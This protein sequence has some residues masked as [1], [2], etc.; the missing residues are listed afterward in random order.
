M[1]VHVF[2]LF[3]RHITSLHFVKMHFCFLMGFCLFYSFRKFLSFL[4]SLV[5]LCLFGLPLTLE[6]SGF[7]LHGSIY[8]Y[9]LSNKYILHS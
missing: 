5:P 8:T 3:F 9:I 1:G 6:Q 2:E 4:I 7:E